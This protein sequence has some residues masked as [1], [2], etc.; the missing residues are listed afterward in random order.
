MT[1]QELIDFLEMF[2]PNKEVLISLSY[3]QY[4][5]ILDTM[6]NEEQPILCVMEYGK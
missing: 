1:A 6:A 3:D 4:F 2:P 5:V